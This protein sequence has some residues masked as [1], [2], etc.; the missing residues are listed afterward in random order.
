M[1]FDRTLGRTLS[2]PEKNKIRTKNI[3]EQEEFKA[4]AKVQHTELSRSGESERNRALMLAN[5]KLRIELARYMHKL[6]KQGNKIRKLKNKA[7][8]QPAQGAV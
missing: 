8:N 4:A 7:G 6:R 1:T 3:I 5:D 2:Q